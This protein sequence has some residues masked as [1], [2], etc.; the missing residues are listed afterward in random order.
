MNRER[1]VAMATAVIAATAPAVAQAKSLD[2]LYVYVALFLGLPALLSLIAGI[3]LSTYV[4]AAAAGAIVGL[5]GIL[6]VWGDNIRPGLFH[7]CFLIG[8]VLMA[9]AAHGLWRWL[10]VPKS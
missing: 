3:A 5:G 10:H 7:I 9:L 8:N 1:N 6:L 2:G 4:K